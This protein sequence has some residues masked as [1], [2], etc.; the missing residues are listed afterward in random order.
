MYTKLNKCNHVPVSGY[1]GYHDRLQVARSPFCKIK[2]L[3]TD[4]GIGS[5]SYVV[6]LNHKN[7][8]F[9]LHSA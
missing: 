5:I 3:I 1:P 8:L 9:T 7:V 6:T 2:E 4:E